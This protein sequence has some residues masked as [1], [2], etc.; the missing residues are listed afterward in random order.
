MPSLVLMK[1]TKLRDKTLFRFE[2][3]SLNEKKMEHIKNELKI[4][5]WNGIL[6]S[7]DVNENFDKFCE[8]VNETMDKFTPLKEVNISWR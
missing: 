8:V 6:R 7:N 3:H 1:Q 4:K 2:S 5:G